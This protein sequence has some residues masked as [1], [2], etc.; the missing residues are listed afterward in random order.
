MQHILLFQ[1]TM[2][3]KN[4]PQCFV[5]RTLTQLSYLQRNQ[6]EESDA[7]PVQLARNIMHCVTSANL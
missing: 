3:A 6:V 4:A 7:P 2:V 5:I 1:D